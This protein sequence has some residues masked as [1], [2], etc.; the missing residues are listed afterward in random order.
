MSL[1]CF[2]DSLGT[3]DTLGDSDAKISKFLQFLV[4]DTG[5]VLGTDKPSAPWFKTGLNH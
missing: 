4:N 5:V 1:D 3:V 2:S